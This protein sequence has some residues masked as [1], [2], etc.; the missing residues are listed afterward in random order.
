MDENPRKKP[1]RLRMVIADA[2]S[3]IVESSER[4]LKVIPEGIL[5]EITE[6]IPGKCRQ[7]YIKVLRY[8]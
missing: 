5:E 2:V 6:G 4:I 7:K 8:Q 1:G 3:R